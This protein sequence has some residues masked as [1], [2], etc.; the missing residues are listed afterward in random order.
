NV[1]TVVGNPGPNQCTA[2]D[3]AVVITPCQI[4]YPFA[5]ANPLT[6]VLFNE[7]EVL[8]TF[9]PNFAGP[10]GT[11]KLFYNDEH[12]LSL[13][14]RQ[15]SVKDAGGTVV[16][17]RPVTPLVAQAGPPLVTC[18]TNPLVCHAVE[19]QVGIKGVPGD[20]AANAPAG[21][22]VSPAGAI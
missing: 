8:R 1:V 18:V 6:S 16:T 19:P 22:P 15:I 9:E 2:T 11:I 13:G 12:T 4:Q 7:S 14:V 21:P 3:Q 5:S 10:G 17:N 20:L